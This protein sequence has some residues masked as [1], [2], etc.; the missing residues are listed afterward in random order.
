MSLYVYV[1]GF[2][3]RGRFGVLPDE[4]AVD[5]ALGIFLGL[6][7]LGF[8][9]DSMGASPGLVTG[10]P[11]FVKKVVFPLEI[12]PAAYVGAAFLRMAIGLTLTLLGAAIFGRGAHWGWLWLFA[13]L[14]S[15]FVLVLGISWLFAALGVFVQDLAQLVGFLVQVT[16]YASA[17]FY[18]PSRMSPAVW[19]IMRFNP[20]LLLVDLSRN[21]VLW[22]RPLN[23]REVAYV[24]VSCAA[25]CYVGH[26]IFC[27]LRPAFADV[28]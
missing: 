4:T 25:I 2:I 18:P 6:T 27:H 11:N 21:A 14:P 12:L 5:F 10:N 19:H 28:L 17:V 8:I 3:F 1:F 7:F 16:M 22:Q 20:F 13:L 24:F 9:A 15:F 26:R 23:L